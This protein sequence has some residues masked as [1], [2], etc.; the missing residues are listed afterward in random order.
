MNLD[1][2]VDTNTRTTKEMVLSEMVLCFAKPRTCLF[3]KKGIQYRFPDN[4][5]IDK[6]WLDITFIPL[7][8]DTDI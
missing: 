7:R 1:M 5:L 8:K 6:R 2:L 3:I 4:T